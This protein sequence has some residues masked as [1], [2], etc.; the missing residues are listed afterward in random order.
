MGFT[1]LKTARLELAEIGP[2]HQEDIYEIWSRDDVMQYYGSDKFTDPEQAAGIIRA[3]G[4]GFAS[5]QAI[6]WGIVL[7]ESG[8]LIGTIG[9]HNWNKRVERAEI[10]Y[11]LHPDYWRKGLAKEAVYAVIDH[12]FN[13]LGIKRMGALVFPENKV[14]AG[15]LQKM[16]FLKEGLLRAY[17]HQEGRSHDSFMFSLLKTEWKV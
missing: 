8:K 12:S 3:F 9:I 13:E 5:G 15:M 14:S 6:R 1:T 16:G 7:K 10:G 2:Q 11:E 17:L 4:E